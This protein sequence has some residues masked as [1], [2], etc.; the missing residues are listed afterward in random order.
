MQS[1]TTASSDDEDII[2]LNSAAL[3]ATPPAPDR[4]P[5]GGDLPSLLKHTQDA[6]VTLNQNLEAEISALKEQKQQLE[7]QLS[8]TDHGGTDVAADGARKASARKLQ[9]RLQ[10][11]TQPLL[12]PLLLVLL[13]LLFVVFHRLTVLSGDKA[14]LQSDVAQ[15]AVLLQEAKAHSLTSQA[16][17]HENCSQV[18]RSVQTK[19]EEAAVEL[20][21]GIDALKLEANVLRNANAKLLAADKT[22]HKDYRQVRET[23]EK[24]LESAEAAVTKLNRDNAAL[25]S[26][27]KQGN[28]KAAAFK[29]LVCPRDQPE[30]AKS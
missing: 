3:P 4:R 1:L 29:H 18:L 14:A 2:V 25:R 24:Q 16:A 22:R 13:L 15:A 21:Q 27:A 12:K 5:V 30:P 8:D 19:R 20:K 23:L 10:S 9:I 28:L 11:L 6:A 17:A 7:K 26:E